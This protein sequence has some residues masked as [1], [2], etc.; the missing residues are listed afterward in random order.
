MQLYT[1]YNCIYMY[2]S[3]HAHII[4]QMT[5]HHNPLIMYIVHIFS[6]ER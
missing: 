2:M 1:I 5:V 3:L 4:M 6:E